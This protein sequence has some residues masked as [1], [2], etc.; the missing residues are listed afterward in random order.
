MNSANGTIALIRGRLPELNP[1]LRRIGL[2]IVRAPAQAKSMTIREM[3]EKCEVS[4]ATVTRFVKEFSFESFQQMKISLAEEL[5]RRRQ[6]LPAKETR[7][8]YDHIKPDDSLD[9]VVRKVH[10]A[11]RETLDQTMM[12]LQ[13]ELVA[14]VV[15]ALS[16]CEY[17]VF[18]ATGTSALA[19]ENGVVRFFRVGK[20]C[21]FYRDQ[22]IQQFASVN[23]DEKCVVFGISNSGRTKATVRALQVARERGA[24]TVCIT[25][26]PSSPITRYADI[27]LIT[28]EQADAIDR[29]DA[30]ESTTAKIGQIAVLDVLYSAYAIRHHRDAVH[31]L[32]ETDRFVEEGK[33]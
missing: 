17:V 14:R 18:F 5:S 6:E 28:A 2:H 11:L 3:A 22:S 10:G 25:S 31:V 7:E 9:I 32:A 21:I 33:V 12:K 27:S 8:I 24:H 23:L 13:P 15:E 29:P 19:A 30:P 4:E 20:K 26:F 16:A 1:A